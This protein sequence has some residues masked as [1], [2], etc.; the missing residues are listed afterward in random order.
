M[1]VITDTILNSKLHHVTNIDPFTHSH[2]PR[3]YLWMTKKNNEHQTPLLIYET[4]QYTMGLLPDK[5][6]YGLRMRRECRERF[7]ATAS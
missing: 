4:F 7:P 1:Y 5:L 2:E 3:K 6:N